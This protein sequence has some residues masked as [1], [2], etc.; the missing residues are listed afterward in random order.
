MGHD[1]AVFADML[2]DMFVAQ[3]SQLKGIDVDCNLLAT[4]LK[5]LQLLRLVSAVERNLA[6][7]L[8]PAAIFEYPNVREFAGFLLKRYPNECSAW[9]SS[10][11]DPASPER[12]WGSASEL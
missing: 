4:Q 12:R 3:E 7:S 9:I 10:I 5:S 11:P 1:Q 6:I 8:S 2:K